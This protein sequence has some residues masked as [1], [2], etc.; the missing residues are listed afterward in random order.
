[1]FIS[2]DG[3]HS[4]WTDHNACSQSLLSLFT[5][6]EVLHGMICSNHRPLSALLGCS[7]TCIHDIVHTG[8]S[9]F[10]HRY[11]TCWECVCN[12]DILRYRC[13]LDELLR[14]VNIPTDLLSCNSE[15]CDPCEHCSF[16]DLYYDKIIGCVVRATENVIPRRKKYTGMI[17]M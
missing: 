10:T 5:D 13:R 7:L 3:L 8:H 1:M 17:V 16:I 4:S 15:C 11:Y 2:D 9:A 12:E 14:N 6:V